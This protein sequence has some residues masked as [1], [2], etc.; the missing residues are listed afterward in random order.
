[1]D[2]RSLVAHFIAYALL[3]LLC[4]L[5]RLARR[6]DL[7]LH[8]KL[9]WTVLLAVYA[10]ADELLQPYFRRHADPLDW[11]ADVAGVLL[12]MLLV[13]TRPSIE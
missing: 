11:L 7:T 12:V 5:V 4:V 1:M 10:A 13:R 9:K 3:A 2:R 6:P 8:W